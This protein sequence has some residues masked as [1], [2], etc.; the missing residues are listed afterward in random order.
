MHASQNGHL[1][2]IRLLLE[3][4]ANVNAAAKVA[5]CKIWALFP[6]HPAP[7]NSTP[8]V[9][10]TLALHSFSHIRT[11]SPL[12]TLAYPRA[13]VG[14]LTVGAATREPLLPPGCSLDS[15]T[16]AP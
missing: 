13:Y 4:G 14:A 9:T 10:P 16:P 3:R 2:V 1:D 5:L 12:A 7:T 15:T 8:A 6:T 11:A